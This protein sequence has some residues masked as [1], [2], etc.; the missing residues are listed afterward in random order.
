MTRHVTPIAEPRNRHLALVAQRPRVNPRHPSVRATEFFDQDDPDLTWG[1]D[2]CV[3]LTAIEAQTIAGVLRHARGHC[4]SPKVVDE[5]IALLAMAS[6]RV[7]R[8]DAS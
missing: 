5:A 6:G 1:A 8:G 3:V 4:P 2:Q 7:N